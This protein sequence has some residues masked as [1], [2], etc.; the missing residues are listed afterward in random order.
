MSLFIKNRTLIVLLIFVILVF[1][2]IIL[3]R[4]GNLLKKDLYTQVENV[5]AYAAENSNLKDDRRV[6]KLTIDQLNYFNDSIIL[7]MKDVQERLKIKDRKIKQLQYQLLTAHRVDTLILRDTIFKDPNFKLDTVLG[8]RW[9]SQRLSMEYPNKIVSSPEITLQN[10]VIIHEEK[11]TVKPRKKF[12]LWR[13]FQK[14]QKVLRVDV[15]EENP[16]VKDSISKF[17]EIVK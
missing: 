16:Y 15:Y 6:F 7:H 8:D 4:R 17:I 10:H 11:E 2:N 9:F 3:Y 13:L 5:K 12:F 14:K 1:S